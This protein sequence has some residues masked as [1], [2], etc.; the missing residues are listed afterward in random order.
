VERV[1]ADWTNYVCKYFPV[2]GELSTPWRWK[3]AGTETFG[4]WLLDV[5]RKLIAGEPID[6]R[7]APS[8]VIWVPLDGSDDERRRLAAARTRAPTDAGTV[9]IIEESTS[10]RRQRLV[11]SQTP[12]AVTVESVDLR[13]LVDFASALDFGAPDA[14]S[15]VVKFAGTV[16]TNVGADDLLQ[17]VDVLERG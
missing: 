9:L 2:A 11:A 4:L 5:R 1:L 13:D 12:G 15:Q 3:N 10:P 8:E 7:V 16:M 14:L 17:R 6:L